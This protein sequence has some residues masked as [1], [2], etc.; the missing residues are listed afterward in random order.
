MR[1]TK[2][3]LE[4]LEKADT[5]AGEINKVPFRTLRALESREL[6][7]PQGPWP[8]GTNNSGD[9]CFPSYNRVKLT[10]AGMKAARDLRKAREAT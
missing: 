4:V 6:I 3:M 9:H 10:T 7:A 8:H 2:R 1:L 5:E